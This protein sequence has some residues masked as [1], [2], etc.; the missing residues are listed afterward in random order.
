MFLHETGSYLHPDDPGEPSTGLPR[1]SVTDE[2]AALL[3]EWV[4]GMTVLEIGTGL[5][6]STRALAESAVTVHTVDVDL[7]VHEMIW[8]YLPDNVVPHKTVGTVPMVDAAFIDGDH[9]LEAV[10]WDLAQATSRASKLLMAHDYHPTEEALGDGWEVMPT[11]HGLAR[12]F[13]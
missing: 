1:L 9:S 4:A 2:E 10:A 6:V 8:P 12:K 3:T 11:A 13:L 7:W 5:G